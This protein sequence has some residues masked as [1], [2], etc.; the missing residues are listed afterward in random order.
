MKNVP[1]L[2]WEYSYILLP[3]GWAHDYRDVGR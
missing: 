1:T 2:F 3:G